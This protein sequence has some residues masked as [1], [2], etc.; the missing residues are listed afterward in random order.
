MADVDRCVCCGE[1]VPEGR[2]VCPQCEFELQSE[3]DVGAVLDIEDKI[4]ENWVKFYLAHP[5]TFCELW[6]L[7]LTFAQK[8]ILRAAALYEGTRDRRKNK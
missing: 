8:I 7:R 5:V 3:P 4:D 6:G 1:I 2:M